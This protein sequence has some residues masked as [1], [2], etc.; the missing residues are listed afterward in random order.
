[1]FKFK[2]ADPI[3][4]VSLPTSEEEVVAEVILNPASAEKIFYKQHLI[5]PSITTSLP[6]QLSA[7]QRH[8]TFA[9]FPLGKLWDQVQDP[10]C[11]QWPHSG[12]R[13]LHI[14]QN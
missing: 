7:G 9:L 2:K 8:P 13:N 11:I 1:M 14:L 12:S 4:H 10:V 3:W 6:H 5:S